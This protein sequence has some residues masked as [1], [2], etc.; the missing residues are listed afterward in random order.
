[1][2]AYGLSFLPFNDL[3][4]QALPE[5]VEQK[6]PARCATTFGCFGSDP[7]DPP[8]PDASEHPF[9]VDASPERASPTD[10]EG[11]RMQQDHSDPPDRSAPGT[12]PLA[13]SR[14][15]K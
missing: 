5:V 3:A 6:I 11:E 1:M 2:A 10:E 8:D 12:S 7:A 13:T 15:E 14:V 4:A 9:V